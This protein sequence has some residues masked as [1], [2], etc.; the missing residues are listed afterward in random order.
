[1]G[2]GNQCV[3]CNDARPE[4]W[5][6]AHYRVSDNTCQPLSH[7]LRNCARLAGKFAGKIGLQK[8]GELVGLLHD[9]GKA[10]DE[11]S[12]YIRSVTG[13]E[14]ADGTD[15]IVDGEMK[16]GTIDHSSAGAQY[17][18]RRL[19]SLGK[20]SRFAA[21]IIALIIA[22]HHSGIVDCL[23]PEGRDNFTQRMQK[24]DE[25]TRLLEALSNLDE[26]LRDYMDKLSSD[27]LLVQ[28]INDAIKRLYEPDDD[29]ESM[30]LKV[31]FLVRYLFS[32][33]I[34]ADR[35]DTADFEFPDR[36]HLRNDR[37]NVSWANLCER[38]E[39][40][41]AGLGVREEVDR[42]RQAVSAACLEFAS[43]P[44][45]LYQLTVP[46][47]GGKTLSSLRFALHHARK[48]NMDRIIY[49]IPYTSI[50]DQNADVIR[51]ILETEKV[52]PGS[53]VLENHSNLTP[54][55]ETPWQRVLAENWDA[56]VVFITMVQF[57][58]ALLGRST[59]DARRMHQLANAVLIFDEIQT[60]PVRCVRLFNVA[61]KFLIKA[62]GSSVVL[63][64]AT[65]PL[66][67]RVEP[68]SMALNICPAQN[69]VPNRDDLFRQLRRVE[70]H[71]Y[72]KAGGWSV[73]EVAELAQIEVEKTDSVLIVVNTKRSARELYEELRRRAT[74][75]VYHLSTNMCPAH[76]LTTLD[77]IKSRLKEKSPV[78]CVSTQLIEAGVD[79]DFGCVIRYIAG[80]DSIVQAA[81]RCNRNGSRPRL[82]QVYIVNPA[83]ENLDKLRDIRI[84]KECAERVL[85]EFAATPEEFDGY[86][87][88]PKAMAQYYE[89][90]FYRRSGEMSYPVSRKS[91]VGRDDTLVQLLSTNC[92]S[93]AAYAR[94][95][96]QAGPNT[97]LVQSFMTASNE[98]EAIDAPTRG[99][100]VPYDEG[101]RI[102]DAL[103]SSHTLAEQYELLRQAQRYS[104]NVY[105]HQ[106][107]I[108]VRQG[109]VREVQ[110]GSGILYLDERYYSKE[111]G[112]TEIESGE[113]ETLEV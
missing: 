26:E 39:K 100:I 50:I 106:L 67:H 69:M 32:C 33:L 109:V 8:A 57:L 95:H 68:R 58:E 59:R 1:M 90:Y 80:L 45:G 23:S 101:R 14:A 30:M 43:H 11:F 71:D 20:E 40:H 82:G 21:Q 102:I 66:L 46:T 52:P 98:F 105:A 29:H 19:S 64:T 97:P 70:V 91:Q 88:S 65:Q 15:S 83:E 9:L 76:R 94:T 110:E 31:G 72:R 60:L 85:R 63:C 56:P 81:G 36:V 34:D 99:V 27:P 87:L 2:A 92:L 74:A 54:E 10:T 79:I 4:Q 13:L 111:Y 77:E 6:I 38:L 3:H 44:K 48:Q 55:K 107:N 37:G 103:A 93:L 86:L 61:I 62:C 41:L 25:E 17:A 89:Y 35:Q 28:E 113:M 47:G 75:E 18:F 7:H 104:V 96:H 5:F 16:R 24:P 49:I 51:R 12:R 112:L 108:L 84:G 53:I 22:S 42:I 78:I 73:E